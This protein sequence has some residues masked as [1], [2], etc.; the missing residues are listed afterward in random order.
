MSDHQAREK[1]VEITPTPTLHSLAFR[2]ADFSTLS[3]ALDYAAKGETGTNFYTGRGKLSVTLPY[4]QLRDESR[5]LARKLMGIGLKKGDRVALIAETTPHFL[6]FFFA[7]QYVGLV[8]VALPASVNLGGHTSYVAQ[9]K[10]LLESSQASVAMAPEGYISFLE[11]AGEGL[12]LKMIGD[13]GHFDALPEKDFEFQPASADDI[14]YMQ[15]T[16]GSTRFPRGVVIKQSAVMSN[17]AGIIRHGVKMGK[18]DRCF[19]WLPFYH[20]MGLVGL[21]LTPVA[22]Q[23]SVDYLDTREFA[24]RPRQWLNL[25]SQTKA[26]ISFSPPFGYELCTRRLR[27][28]EASKYDLSNWRVAGVGAEMI[29][30]E[31]LQRFSKALAPAG[32]DE[33]AFLA[34]Y[35]MA[36]CSLAISF[37][38][39]FKGHKTDCVDG[40]HHSDHQ[41]ALPIELSENPGRARCFVDCGTPLPEYE[42]EIRNA[43]GHSL[44]D[45]HSGSI[46]VRGPSVMSGYFNEP[47]ET[48]NA[49]SEDG[50]LNTGDIGYR[51]DGSLIITGRQKDLIIINGRNI[52]PQDLEYLAEHQPEVRTSD[53]LAFSVPLTDDELCVLVVQCRESDKGKRSALMD[54]IARLVRMEL[55]IDCYVELVPLHTLP[56]TSS[57]KLSRSK[58][59]QN[60]IDSHDLSA[61]ADS[62]ADVPAIN[63]G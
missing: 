45:R 6:R 62:V 5:I 60:F 34:C 16:S 17:L 25:L 3:E 1:I 32:F 61:L 22:A 42:V 19:S 44:K 30:S 49:L 26:T 33:K 15:Y 21:V 41:E 10:G 58:A 43:K 50:W 57:G 55:G 54:R 63:Q 56:R 46:F 20:D 27:P 9:L 28:G 36:E 48:R 39:L 40:D 23:I 4:R 29:R 14:A 37:S 53:A 51:V 13:P 7:C 8:P 11:E 52:W 38:P 24:M 31:T 18:G 35:G 59:R 2:D 47:E 12:G